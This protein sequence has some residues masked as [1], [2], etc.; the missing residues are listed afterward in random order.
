MLHWALD[1]QIC[2]EREEYDMT[3]KP[4]E[5]SCT[6]DATPVLWRYLLCHGD[7]KS[8]GEDASCWQAALAMNNPRLTSPR[9]SAEGRKMNSLGLIQYLSLRPL[10]SCLVN[11]YPWFY[12]C[13]LPLEEGN[14]EVILK[15]YNSM[16]S[17][18]N[19]ERVYDCLS[20]QCGHIRYIY[21][22]LSQLGFINS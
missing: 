10:F 13:S 4:S 5:D 1:Y 3:P 19:T 18:K 21:N 15:Y 2:L 17:K 22:V 16:Y 9:D 8:L 14:L 12:L 6:E 20:T 11:K 7:T